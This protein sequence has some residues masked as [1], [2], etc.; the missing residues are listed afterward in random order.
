MEDLHARHKN[1]LMQHDLVGCQS[2]AEIKKLRAHYGQPDCIVA[3][4]MTATCQ[5]TDLMAAKK[6]HDIAFEHQVEIKRW[7]REKAR[8]LN[9]DVNYAIGPL[10]LM[11]I[12]NVIHDGWV[13][14]LNE[15]DWVLCGAR[16]GGHLAYLPDMVEKRLK[17]FEELAKE[18]P[19]LKHLPSLGG[20]KINKQWL[21]DRFAWLSED[22]VP[23]KPDWKEQEK[24]DATIRQQRDDKRRQELSETSLLITV[25]EQ[26]LFNQ[27]Q[28][29]LQDHPK[30]RAASYRDLVAVSGDLAKAKLSKAIGKS[31]E[32]KRARIRA[33]EAR[34][35]LHPDYLGKCRQYLKEGMSTENLAERVVLKAKK[36]KKKAPRTAAHLAKTHIKKLS[37]MAVSA[38]KRARKAR[39]LELSAVAPLDKELQAGPLVGKAVRVCK[40]LL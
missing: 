16:Q 11:L 22:G 3:A 9:M 21:E 34:R 39:T 5:V 33:K 18:M 10:E 30:V 26:E 36:N 27:D 12:A 35:P 1:V 14:W 20:P 8:E 23:K 19:D 2:T 31:A 29:L 15:A 13:S 7:L 24:T 28:A 25:D 38:A 40:D 6:A 37:K 17:P 4:D 32:K